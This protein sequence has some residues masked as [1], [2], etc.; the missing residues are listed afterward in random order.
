MLNS[1]LSKGIHTREK[2][3]KTGLVRGF[4]VNVMI[5]GYSIDGGRTYA[6][7]WVQSTGSFS[8]WGKRC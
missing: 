7:R 1:T 8:K 2:E 6:K 5:R 4:L 3:G